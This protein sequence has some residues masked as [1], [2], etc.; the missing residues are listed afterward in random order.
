MVYLLL[1][2]TNIYRKKYLDDLI[3]FYRK[4]K[5]P[6]KLKDLDVDIKEIAPVIEK[7]IETGE[8]EHSPYEIGY[9]KIKDAIGKL[10]IYI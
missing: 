2:L 9:E 3:E 8:V 10:E 4:I 1:K 6:I 5:L 7:G